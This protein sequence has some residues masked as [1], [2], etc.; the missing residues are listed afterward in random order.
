MDPDLVAQVQHLM[1][2]LEERQ[3]DA[4]F[5][6]Q[7]LVTLQ[8]FMRFAPTRSILLSGSQVTALAVHSSNWLTELIAT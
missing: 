8:T 1:A 6:L 3:Q 7:I 4:E 5:V 2:L